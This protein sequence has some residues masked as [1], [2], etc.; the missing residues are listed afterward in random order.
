MYIINSSSVCDP[1]RR[2]QGLYFRSCWCGVWVLRLR[3]GAYGLGF[4]CRVLQGSVFRV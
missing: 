3:A 1:L 4:G 2:V